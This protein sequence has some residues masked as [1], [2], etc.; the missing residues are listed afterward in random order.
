MAWVTRHA[1]QERR[2]KAE[3]KA[4]LIKAVL[5]GTWGGGKTGFSPTWRGAHHPL[6]GG[7]VDPVQAPLN[8]R[9]AGSGHGPR[10][11][12]LPLFRFRDSFGVSDRHS[13]AGGGQEFP[14]STLFKAVSLDPNHT[15]R[16]SEARFL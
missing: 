5:D 9:A 11:R 14:Q 15:N 7:E 2:V 3:E 13:V 10:D 8:A 4:L 16:S 1:G 12:R 6:T